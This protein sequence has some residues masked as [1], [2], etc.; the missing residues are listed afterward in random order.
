MSAKNPNSELE[1]TAAQYKQGRDK[2]VMRPELVYEGTV[3]PE[4]DANYIEAR[5]YYADAVKVCDLCGKAIR[6]GDSYVIRT[7]RL[8]TVFNLCGD[9]CE[10]E[11]DDPYS[12]YNEW[13][14]GISQVWF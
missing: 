6:D 11:Y 3:P 4:L 7:D 5:A 9:A 14:T 2:A 8:G 12:E 13:R 10:D 1:G